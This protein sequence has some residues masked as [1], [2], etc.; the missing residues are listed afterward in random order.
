MSALS[1]ILRKQEGDRLAWWCPGCDEAHVI[2][3]A[4]G[5]WT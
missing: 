5:G 3:I 2:C 1:K 4:A